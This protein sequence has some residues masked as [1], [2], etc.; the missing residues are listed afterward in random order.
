M[1][2][3]DR[4]K[5]LSREVQSTQQ[6]AMAIRKG[7]AMALKRA[8]RMLKDPTRGQGQLSEDLTTQI[9]S[10]E[11]QYT[12]LRR[13]LAAKEDGQQDHRKGLSRVGSQLAQRE[14]Q[15]AHA[16]EEA[17]EA[18]L[19]LGKMEQAG[20]VDSLQMAELSDGVKRANELER[21]VAMKKSKLEE[22]DGVLLGLEQEL[23]AEMARLDK[24]QASNAD[25]L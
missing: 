6:E 18:R 19:E 20:E 15:L 21:I 22:Q 3:R 2:I 17:E 7:Q 8:H 11:R 14:K 9:A 16:L 4:F 1:C 13:E 12:E 5:Q 10:L 25:H 23:A 24:L